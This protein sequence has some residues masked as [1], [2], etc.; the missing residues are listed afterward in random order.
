MIETASPPTE[1]LPTAPCLA[2]CSFTPADTG[3]TSPM[4]RLDLVFPSSSQPAPD[5]G[6]AQSW[7]LTEPDASFDGLQ[8]SGTAE[9]ITVRI[10]PGASIRRLRN[11]RC[12]WPRRF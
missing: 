6:I 7:A 8:Q 4:N 5:S 12:A 11:N 10:K 1:E 9:L 2:R 3:T